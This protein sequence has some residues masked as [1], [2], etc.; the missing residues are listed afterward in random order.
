MNIM[1]Y[2]TSRCYNTKCLGTKTSLFR[3]WSGIES[4]QPLRVRTDMLID[5]LMQS[6]FSTLQCDDPSWCQFS[7]K[8]HKQAIKNLKT[9]AR[10]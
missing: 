8:T 1:T 3:K 2:Y 4:I 7:L 9:E 6:V 5:W 10:R